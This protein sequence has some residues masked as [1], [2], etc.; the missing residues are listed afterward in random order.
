MNKL[1]REGALERLSS[2][3]LRVISAEVIAGERGSTISKDASFVSSSKSDLKSLPTFVAIRN[4]HAHSRHTKHIFTCASSD[5]VVSWGFR[6]QENNMNLRQTRQDQADFT[7]RSCR[8]GGVIRGVSLYR[9]L[10]LRRP[11][12]SEKDSIAFLSVPSAIIL[13]RLMLS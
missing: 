13:T 11:L 5:S 10:Y 2:A 4:S 9:N 12:H 6:L 1:R 8:F 7:S 3:L